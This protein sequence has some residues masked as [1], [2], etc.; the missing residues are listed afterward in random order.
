M[1]RRVQQAVL[2]TRLWYLGSLVLP[3]VIGRTADFGRWFSIAQV[4]KPK[5]GEHAQ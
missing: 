2:W 1:A 5:I 3:R 4:G